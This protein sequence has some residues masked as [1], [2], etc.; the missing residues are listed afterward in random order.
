M[1]VAAALAIGTPVEATAA[2]AA[3]DLSKEVNPFVGT[4]SEGNAYPGATLPF[5]MVQ[6]SPDN[7]NTYGSTSYSHDAG[8]GVGLQPPARQQR[9]LPRRR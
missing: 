1:A 6:L 7:T 2:P 4:E 3:T 9:W 8:R 5:G